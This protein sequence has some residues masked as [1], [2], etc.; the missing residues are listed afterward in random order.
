M[1]R[2]ARNL[3]LDPLS[4]E[5]FRQAA[6]IIGEC[7]DPTPQIRWP[8]LAQRLGVDVWVKHEN[9]LPTGAFKVRGGLVFMRQLYEKGL[10]ETGVIAA[11]RGNHGQ[12][13]AFAAD[14]I[15]VP[16][17]IVVPYGNNVDKNRAMKAYGANLIEA[18][19]DFDEALLTDRNLATEHN[20]F[21][22]PSFD[23][24]LVQGVGTYAFEMFL[25]LPDLD[26]V[27]VS[28]GLGSGICG[29]LSAR[30]ALG[31]KTEVIGVVSTK[32]D[33][34]AQSIDKGYLVTTASA[35]TIADGMAVRA[36]S[37]EAFELLK[38]RV[39]RVVRVSDEEILEAIKFYYEDTHNLAEGAGAAPLAA[40][41]KEKEIYAGKRV[42][43]ILS[44]GNVDEE[45]LM[46]AIGK[47]GIDKR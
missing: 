7:I 23:P 13:I 5:E 10:G 46:R 25:E 20:L 3:L 11:T 17:T 36:P 2:N 37:P 22:V 24:V 19:Y 30:D 40:L 47:R 1:D 9:H 28:I 38:D 39:S 32:A 43:L 29:I 12:S 45:T 21:P 34:Y 6:E 14:R 18:G 27:F 35:E 16:A 42:G 26:V 44:G 31:L 8:L 15:G 4:V 41:Y 33:A